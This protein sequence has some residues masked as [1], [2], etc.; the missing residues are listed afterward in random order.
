MALVQ[1]QTK[2]LEFLELVGRLKVYLKAELYL[3]KLFLT[4]SHYIFLA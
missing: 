1:D 4:V 2:I 3:S